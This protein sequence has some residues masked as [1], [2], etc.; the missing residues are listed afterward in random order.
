[1]G[2]VRCFAAVEI[3]Q[4]TRRA[5]EALLETL[6]P[7]GWDTRWVKPENLHLTLK[8]LGDVEEQRSVSVLEAL[9]G[10]AR[11]TRAFRLGLKGVGAF[12]SLGRPRV[13]WIGVDQGRE[14]LVGLAKRIDAAVAPL[15]FAREDR[16]FSPHLTLGRRQPGPAGPELERAL[17]ERE[18][19][20]FPLVKVEGVTLFRSILGPGGP[21]YRRLGQVA[22]ALGGEDGPKEQTREVVE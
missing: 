20:R 12:P 19:L 8:F 1:M 17:R 16:P 14:D 22:L 13:L 6:G 21:V 3:S 5:L 4:E 10:A 9:E 11:E 15:G 2:H 18:T 7:L